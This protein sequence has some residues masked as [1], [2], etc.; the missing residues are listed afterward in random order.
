MKDKFK[1]SII[2]PVYQVEPY[3]AECVNSLIH[4]TIDSCQL[5]F[6]NNGCKDNSVNILKSL[7]EKRDDVVIIDLNENV[8]LAQ[9]RNIGMTYAEGEYIAFVDSDDVCDTTMYEKLYNTALREVADCVICNVGMFT[10]SSTALCPRWPQTWYNSSWTGSISGLPMLWVEMAAWGKLIKRS[11]AE[12]VGFGFTKDS[13]CCEEVPG[14][15]KLFLKAKRISTLPEMLYC[16]RDRP[17]S[18]SKKINDKFLSDF[19]YAISQQDAVLRA[20][21][22]ID[23]LS[24]AYINSMRMIIANHLLLHSE[25]KLYSLR[26]AELRAVLGTKMSLFTNGPL[27]F[28]N[29]LH[30]NHFKE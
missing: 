10:S 2:V 28:C 15:T 6:I 7:I 1:V 18:L 8:G 16:Y 5:I 21:G 27:A 29:K 19:I 12:E 17:G 24:T 25:A 14:M 9:A 11:L 22:Y 13:L 20:H 23:N 30:Q 4:Q 26:V 3:I